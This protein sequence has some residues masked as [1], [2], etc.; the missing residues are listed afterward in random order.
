MP[1]I[2]V[3]KEQLKALA[4]RVRVIREAKELTQ[5]QLANRMDRDKQSI[6]RLERGNLNPTYI[7]LQQLAEAFEMTVSSLTETL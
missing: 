4:A 7:Y 5:E 1:A 2:P 6:Q 3:N